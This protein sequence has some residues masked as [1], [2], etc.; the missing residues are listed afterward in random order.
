MIII[1]TLDGCPACDELKRTLKQKGLEYIEIEIYEYPHVWEE[2][3]N[4]TKVD[5]VPTMLLKQTVDDDSDTEEKKSNLYVAGV[6]FNNIN[7]A[8]EIIRNYFSN[9]GA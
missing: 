8:I 9:K 3:V 6:D 1:F 4:V 7:E 5:S 2:V